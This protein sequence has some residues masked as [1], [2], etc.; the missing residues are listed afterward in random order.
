MK[1]LLPPGGGHAQLHLLRERAAAPLAGWA[2]TLIMPCRRLLYSGVLPGWTAGPYRA[3]NLRAA[4]QGHP[5]R[6]WASQRR[7][8]QRLGT[9]PR[10]A[11]AL[12]GGAF[13]VA[14]V[15]LRRPVVRPRIHY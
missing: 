14:L 9:G 15:C 8:W 2:A 13:C 12:R 11:L 3:A 1:L 6:G 7:A 10:H 4:A 5:V